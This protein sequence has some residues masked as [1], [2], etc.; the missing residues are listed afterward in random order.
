MSRRRMAGSPT[1]R[2]GLGV[3]VQ[4]GWVTQTLSNT[5]HTAA[6]RIATAVAPAHPLER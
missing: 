6:E 1:R 2:A 4:N 3:V 5:A